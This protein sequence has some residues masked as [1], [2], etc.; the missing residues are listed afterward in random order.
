MRETTPIQERRSDTSL[1]S[2]LRSLV[3]PRPLSAREALLITEAQARLLLKSAG[4][5]EPPVPDSLI[6]DLPRLQ[7]VLEAG[8]PCS[9]S[10]HWTG[11]HWLI[12]LNADEPML[13]RR[14]SLYHEYK[15]IVDHPNR[16]WLYPPARRSSKV[17]PE[18]LA[19]YFAGSV[20][21]PKRLLKR[22]YCEGH[23]DLDEL[24]SI[25][26]VSTRALEVR[27][28]QL[29]LR[30]LGVPCKRPAVLIQGATYFRLSSFPAAVGAAA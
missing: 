4:L 13:R 1:L 11:Q 17:L 8:M 15:H 29:G 28:H 14:F 7:V 2:R 9:G 10:A 3:P 26:M 12:S 25:F 16:D 21:M 5:S 18:Q 22:F 20:L 23:T 24:S 19:D 6:T 30:D 27:L